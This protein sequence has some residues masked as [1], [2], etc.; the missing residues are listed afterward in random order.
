MQKAIKALR[1]GVTKLSGSRKADAGQALE[2]LMRQACFFAAGFFSGRGAILSRFLPFGI[3]AAAGCPIPYLLSTGTG[4]LLSCLFPAVGVGAFRYLSAVFAVL[5]IRTLTQKIR[6]TRQSP[7]FSGGIAFLSSFVTGAALFREVSGGALFTL[8]E[9]LLAF[10]GAYF[11]HIGSESLINGDT[12]LSGERMAGVTV[13]LNLALLGLFSFTPGGISLGH[14]A[15]VP[16]I[17]IAGR[18]GSPGTGTAFG[19]TAAFCSALSGD[20]TGAFVML[21]LGSLLAGTF[22]QLGKLAQA[23]AFLASAGIGALLDGITRA[24]LLLLVEAA[25][26][27]AFYLLLPRATAVRLGKVFCGAIQVEKPGGLKK[28]LTMRLRFASRALQDVSETVDRVACE[29]SRRN[30][31]EFKQVLYQIEQESCQ[32]C[33]LQIYCWETKYDETLAAVL[34]MT[35][36][37]KSGEC[38]PEKRC[39]GE[40]KGRCLRAS[41]MGNAAYKYYSAYAARQAAQVRI[42]EVRNVVSDQFTGISRMLS[43]LAEEFDAEERYDSSCAVRISSA[44]KNINVSVSQCGVK[45]DREDRMHIEMQIRDSKDTVLNRASI[46]H[47]LAA[48]CDRDFDPPCITVVGKDTYL[49]ISEHAYYTA[50]IGVSQICC[51][52][53]PVCGDAYD[54][55]FDGNGRLVL[56]LSD[57]MGTGGRAA[58]DGAMASGL[59]SRLLKAGFDYDSALKILNS[60]M[61]FKSTDESTATLDV[62]SVD[63]YTGKTTLLKAGAAPTLIRRNGKAGK[64]QSTSLPAGILREIG[65]DRAVISLKKGDLILMMSDGAVSE[66]TDWISEE[67]EVWGNDGAQELAERIAASAKRRRTDHHEDDITVLAAILK[68]S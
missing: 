10:C 46:M 7:L 5:A 3:S 54:T 55:F 64:A 45:L 28:S 23:A 57:G 30:A 11:F 6:I 41:R 19:V 8:T 49:S 17:L 29:L 40:F 9:S 63:L 65:F 66:G 24:D 1:Q 33:T 39:S 60:S 26:G 34:D 53:N 27:C 20:A 25:L 31:P 68:K 56:I 47:A 59:M 48:S 35:K 44:L 14:I 37:V 58:V 32:G 67:I 51:G 4:V 21:S 13:V 42:D 62:I 16:L 50:E 18:F 38:S 43:C 12:G 61:L 2:I 52:N 22:S 15:A 36:A